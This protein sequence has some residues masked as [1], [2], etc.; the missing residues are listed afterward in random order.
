MTGDRFIFAF[1]KKSIRKVTKITKT[2]AKSKMYEK[3][4][5]ASKQIGQQ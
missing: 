4:D 3:T 2:F 5:G 1:R